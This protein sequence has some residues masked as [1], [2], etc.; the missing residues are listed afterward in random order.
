MYCVCFLG[1]PKYLSKNYTPKRKPTLAR[2]TAKSTEKNAV[3]SVDSLSVNT[4]KRKTIEP[5]GDNTD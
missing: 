2:T 1:C 3:Q 4:R 5:D